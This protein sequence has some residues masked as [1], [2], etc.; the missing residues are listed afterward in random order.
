MH[1]TFNK[2]ITDLKGKKQNQDK[3][4]NKIN[5]AI[6]YIIKNKIGD[7]TDRDKYIERFSLNPVRYIHIRISPRFYVPY[8]PD[9]SRDNDHQQYR[10]EIKKRI[11]KSVLLD[12]HIYEKD[13]QRNQGIE[14][15][16]NDFRNF[17]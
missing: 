6:P 14:K 1:R 15:I 7:N 5:I 3:Q 13:N 8:Q 10:K 9:D 16:G 17:M 11:F 4:H 2:K 12:T